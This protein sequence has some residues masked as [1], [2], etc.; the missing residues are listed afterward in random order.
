[1]DYLL[2]DSS[3]LLLVFGCFHGRGSPPGR[4]ARL[5]VRIDHP[6]RALARALV[7]HPHE[8]VVQRQI[9]SYRILNSI[10]FN[11]IQ[12]PIQEE[13]RKKREEEEEEEGEE[14]EERGHICSVI[15]SS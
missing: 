15:L 5:G 1:M 11:S 9:M 3:A 4:L 12:L 14:E 7:L 8:P 6:P 2:F 13:T 10:Q